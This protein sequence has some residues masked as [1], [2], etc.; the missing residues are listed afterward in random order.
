M[1]KPAAIFLMAILLTLSLAGA[2]SAQ[3]VD[4]FVEDMETGELVD[5]A[6]VGSEVLVNVWAFNDGNETLEDPAVLVYVEPE[7]A[8]L[9][10]PDEAV[11]DFNGNVFINDPFD[12]FFYWDD[13]FN[14]WVFWIGW[15]DYFMDPDDYA[16][17]FVPA[18]V[19][20]TGEITVY[21]E[22]YEWPEQFEFPILLAEDSYTFYGIECPV[23]PSAATVPMQK[24]GTPLAVAALGILSLIGG[25]AYS[26]L[27]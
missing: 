9:L 17:L 26:K 21:A 2:V 23:E 18:T 22:F 24:T 15:Y 7:M 11:A 27:R 25:V 19:T 20:Q 13:D 5:E 1:R 10:N 4:V 16:G 14:S 3:E 6:C 8:L 12:P